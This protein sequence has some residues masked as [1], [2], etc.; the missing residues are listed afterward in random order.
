MVATRSSRIAGMTAAKYNIQELFE[1]EKFGVAEERGGGSGKSKE[2]AAA[3]PSNGSPR[4]TYMAEFTPSDPP[5]KIWFVVTSSLNASPPEKIQVPE[6]QV[7]DHARW[8]DEYCY[9]D[10]EERRQFGN[11]V[12]NYM[13][14]R[15]G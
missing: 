9:L 11:S 2:K 8:Y 5:E 6:E 4:I 14:Q 1:A 15:M 3:K 7:P 13:R 12:Q 10:P